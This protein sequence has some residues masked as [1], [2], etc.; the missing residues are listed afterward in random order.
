LPF[1]YLHPSSPLSLLYKKN[2]KSDITSDKSRFKSKIIGSRIKKGC[3]QKFELNLVQLSI[4]GFLQR[5]ISSYAHEAGVRCDSVYRIEKCWLKVGMQ[6]SFK[7]YCY[8][9]V[10]CENKPH[11][12]TSDEHRDHSRPLP[13]LE[14]AIE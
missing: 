3:C 7:I 1:R 13:K 14:N 2:P 8:L 6:G 12:W 5:K 9:F 10:R 4:T 11:P